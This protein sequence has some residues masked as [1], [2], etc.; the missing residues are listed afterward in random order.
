MHKSRGGASEDNTIHIATN[1][2]AFNWLLIPD[3]M[4]PFVE[5]VASGY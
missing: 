5:R 2:P 1:S 4:L 3:E